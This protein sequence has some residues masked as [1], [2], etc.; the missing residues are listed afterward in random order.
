MLR[1]RV[2]GPL[3]NWFRCFS[4]T[5]KMRG[6][7]WLIFFLVTC[8]LW[9][10]IKNNSVPFIVHLYLNDTASLFC[11]NCADDA[12]LYHQ[13]VTNSYCLFL[14]RWLMHCSCQ[15]ARLFVSQTTLPYCLQSF[16]YLFDGKFIQWSSVVRYLGI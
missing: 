15:S 4:T 14:H 9:G 11:V 16:T 2:G 7:E 13:I 1:I 6:F 8:D 10:A 12:T 5:S 3:L